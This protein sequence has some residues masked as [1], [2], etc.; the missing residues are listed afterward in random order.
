[1]TSNSAAGL[2]AAPSYYCGYAPGAPECETCGILKDCPKKG[3]WKRRVAKKPNRAP[4]NL[5]PVSGWS[6]EGRW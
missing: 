3:Q 4:K 5:N 6:R 2:L 1:M